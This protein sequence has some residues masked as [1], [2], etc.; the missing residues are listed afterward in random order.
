MLSA[1]EQGR[2]DFNAC[3]VCHSVDEGGAARVGP[4]LFGIYGEPAGQ[5]DGFAYS[6][7]LRDSGLTWDDATLDAFMENPQALVRANRMA[8]AGQRDAEK[9]ANII[10]Y[11]KTL[12]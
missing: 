7:A 12:Q 6:Q 5:R 2:K 11:L 10:A 1:A 8:Y 3:A 9:R 4:N